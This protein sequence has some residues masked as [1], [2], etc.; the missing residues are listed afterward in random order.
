VDWA[1]LIGEQDWRL[2]EPVL[3]AALARGVRFALG[4]GL[5]FSA[6]SGHARHT[7]DID[8]Y[9]L[10]AERQ[11]LIDLVTAA[12]FADYYDSLP[13][14]RRWIYRGRRDGVIVDVIW[15]MANR[16]AEVAD[17]WLTRG[18]TLDLNGLT[19]RLLPPE[20]LL[21]TKLYVMQRDR[22]DWPD[23]LNILRASGGS[24][25]WEHLLARVGDDVGL[26][27]GLL[28]VYAWLC[29]GRVWELPPWLWGRVGLAAPRPGLGACDPRRVE[30]L[31]S[32]DWFG[33]R[34]SAAPGSL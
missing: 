32:R 10:P 15:Q 14:D 5:A 13:Y 8:L 31:D 24:L 19:L 12:G 29:P 28:S 3:A 11:A 26:V 30:L 18:P 23:L 21:W 2:Y 27:G 16:R 33:E 4:G 20:E 17:D 34:H 6:Y 1:A 7:K 9:V 22:C 25:N